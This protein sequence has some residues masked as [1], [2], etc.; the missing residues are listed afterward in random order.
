MSLLERI[1][2]GNLIKKKLQEF[3]ASG[4]GTID[5]QELVE[6][7][8][9]YLWKRNKATTIRQK[10]VLLQQ[11]TPYQFFDYKTIQ[12]QTHQQSFSD[13]DDFSDLF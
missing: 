4:Y 12:I 7:C 13:L 5:R 8:E 1:L 3:K 9:N 6:Y 2:L 10:R 11:A